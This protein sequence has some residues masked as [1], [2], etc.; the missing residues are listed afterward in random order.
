MLAGLRGS[1]SRVPEL[2]ERSTQSLVVWHL[3]GRQKS[4]RSSRRPLWS[5]GPTPAAMPISSSPERQTRIVSTTTGWRQPD[6]SHIEKPTLQDS[7]LVTAG[8]R[9]CLLCSSSVR[10]EAGTRGST[11]QPGTHFRGALISLSH[12]SI[13]DAETQLREGQETPPRHLKGMSFRQMQTG[14]SQKPGGEQKRAGAKG[15]LL[16]VSTDTKL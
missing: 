16:C 6:R 2:S 7:Q 11:D 4:C 12:F 3:P 1:R 5:Q 8:V 10:R 14:E 15:C 13:Q 9:R